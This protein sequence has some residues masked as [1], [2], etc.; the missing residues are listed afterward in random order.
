MLTTVTPPGALIDASDATLREHLRLTAAQTHQ[1]TAI[2][3]YCNTAA[4]HVEAYTRRRLLTQTLRLTLDG[5][6]PR[7]VNLETAPVQSIVAVRYVDGAGVTQTLAAD[8]YRLIDSLVPNRVFP[9]Y[10]Q[11]F[12]TP[13]LDRAVVEVDF[14]AGF[15]DAAADVPADILQAIRMLV[16]HWFDN[17]DAVIVGTSADAMPFAIR[18]LLDPWR[19]WL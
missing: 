16:A 3:A 9:T 7:G 14:V 18:S 15:G 1:D 2:T 8:R 6:G 13:R 4:A 10:R 19:L 11:T 17:R 12:P 5:F